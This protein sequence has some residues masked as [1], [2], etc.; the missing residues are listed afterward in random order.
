MA[1]LLAE[2]VCD[3]CGVCVFVKAVCG[4]TVFNIDIETL[5]IITK[6]FRIAFYLMPLHRISID[7]GV[8]IE[9]T[10]AAQHFFGANVKNWWSLHVVGYSGGDDKI[11]CHTIEMLS[12]SLSDKRDS[13]VGAVL[14]HRRKGAGISYA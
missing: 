3:V 13:F 10:N 5:T 9:E 12:L 8:L 14:S 1:S 4:Q 7:F 11:A 2:C 6:K